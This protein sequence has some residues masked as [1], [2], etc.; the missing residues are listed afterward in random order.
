M[1]QR[2]P[3]TF[4]KFPQTRLDESVV[5]CCSLWRPLV[6]NYS[7]WL[8]K[9][10]LKRA[11]QE[12]SVSRPPSPRHSLHTPFPREVKARA[13]CWLPFRRIFI[14][15]MF[16]ECRHSL[17]SFHRFP[18]RG[19]NCVPILVLP[20]D[21]KTSYRHDVCWFCVTLLIVSS[22][23]YSNNRRV[24]IYYFTCEKGAKCTL[25]DSVQICQWL[26]NWPVN[27]QMIELELNSLS[28]NLNKLN[29]EILFRNIPGLLNNIF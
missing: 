19:S 2:K 26:W 3:K 21:L 16:A 29:K 5:S 23:W 6:C 14:H 25:I 8:P 28:F 24:L 11:Y 27:N 9:C 20:P 7:G 17:R 1:V 13:Q 10:F 22:C 18:T 4:W 12:Q 15:V